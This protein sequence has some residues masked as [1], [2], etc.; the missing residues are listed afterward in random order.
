M[1]VAEK[2]KL[3]NLP[4][5]IIQA[6]SKHVG[7]RLSKRETKIAGANGW[8][9]DLRRSPLMLARRLRS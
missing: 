2:R 1:A 4:Y 9:P 7:R 8:N 5:K 3:W 6:H